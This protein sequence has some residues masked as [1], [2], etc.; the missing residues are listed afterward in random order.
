M[1]RELYC[2]TCGVTGKPV[3]EEKGGCFLE[4]VLW[5]LLLIPGIIYTIWRRTG[6]AHEC[7]NCGAKT[8]VP[9]DSPAARKIPER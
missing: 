3:L 9:L 2:T 6:R 1:A 5:L 8:L 7:A 4:L